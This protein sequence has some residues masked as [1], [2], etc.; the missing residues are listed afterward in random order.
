MNN[1]K[2]YPQGL[3][4]CIASWIPNEPATPIHF[5]LFSNFQDTC[6]IIV[7]SGQD[8]DSYNLLRFFQ[9]GDNWHCSGDCI[10]DD[11]TDVLL[12]LQHVLNTRYE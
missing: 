11:I 2:F 5:E 8:A 7:D 3:K 12:K 4:D 6:I 1:R 9:I 10:N